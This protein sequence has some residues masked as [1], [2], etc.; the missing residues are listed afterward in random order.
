M[1]NDPTEASDP[2]PDGKTPRLG[3]ALNMAAAAERLH[4]SRSLLKICLKRGFKSFKANRS[5]DCDLFLAEYFAVDG[6]LD[7]QI[8]SDEH[9]KKFRALNEELAYNEGMGRMIDRAEWLA[10]CEGLGTLI[11]SVLA[12][13]FEDLPPHIAGK[14]VASIRV[15]LERVT[16]PK[17][18]GEWKAFAARQNLKNKPP[19]S[20]K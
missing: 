16:L 20:T 12:A 9:Y 17:I 19:E 4:C 8:D 15:H 13:E 6:E 3:I 5:I 7:G 2:K 18:I 11:S 14:D 10:D 1:T